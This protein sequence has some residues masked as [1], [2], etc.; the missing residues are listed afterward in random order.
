MASAVVARTRLDSLE[1]LVRTTAPLEWASSSKDAAHYGSVR[2]ATRE[3]MRLPSKLRA[4]AMPVV[5]QA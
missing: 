4:F 1:Y 3:A 2:E 5:G